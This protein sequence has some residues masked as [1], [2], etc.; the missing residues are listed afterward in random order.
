MIIFVGYN[1]YGNWKKHNR[2]LR[3]VIY[4]VTEDKN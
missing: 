3:I 2:I 1:I 4:N